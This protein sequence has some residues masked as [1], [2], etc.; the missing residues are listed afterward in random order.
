MDRSALLDRARNK[1]VNP[2]VYWLVRG[3][4]QPFF[5]LYFRL[6]RIGREHVPQEGPVIFAANHR[7]HLDAGLILTSL[8]EPWRHRAFAAAAADYFFDTRVKATM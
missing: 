3:V 8:P 7:S 1:G 6:S 4:L 5:H 2:L